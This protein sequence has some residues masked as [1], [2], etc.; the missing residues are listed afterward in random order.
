MV[1]LDIS[2]FSEVLKNGKQ[3]C[4]IFSR[5]TNEDVMSAGFL[6]ERFEVKFF[7]VEHQPVLY[8]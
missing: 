1:E 4:Q 7:E 3:C 8:K 6:K 2:I 5:R